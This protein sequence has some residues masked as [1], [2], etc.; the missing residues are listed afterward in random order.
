MRQDRRLLAQFGRE[1]SL[2]HGLV[3]NRRRDTGAGQIRGR[4]RRILSGFVLDHLGRLKRLLH[5]V[6]GCLHSF[7]RVHR[8]C[9]AHIHPL[10]VTRTDVRC[11]RQ[12][13]ECRPKDLIELAEVRHRSV[14][15]DSFQ[16]SWIWQRG[17]PDIDVVDGSNQSAKLCNELRHHQLGLIDQGDGV[18]DLLP[19]V[20]QSLEETVDVAQEAVGSA[21][22]SP[23][24]IRNKRRPPRRPR[25]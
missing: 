21:Q 1:H 5:H 13:L 24:G 8:Q 16:R 15:H 25:R 14:P 2:H 23:N 22:Q 9:V 19:Q 6:I 10:S 4:T 11:W 3:F 17:A 7:Q 12:R 18:D 20:D